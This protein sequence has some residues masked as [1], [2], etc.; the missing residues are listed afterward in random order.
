M[1][2]SRTLRHLSSPQPRQNGFSLIELLV[3]MAI[4]GIL[5][6]IAYPAYTQHKIKSSRAAAQSYMLE[7][8]VAQVSF[9][10]DRRRYAT[11]TTELSLAAPYEVS[12]KYTVRIDA[13]NTSRPQSFLITA[14]PLT[15]SIQ[16]PD[17]ELTLSSTGAKT[18]SGKW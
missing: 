13:V 1:S 15:N 2:H 5:S 4:I 6:A 18:P 9:L 7:L 8:G 14:V 3:T 12:S 11:S 16:S 17:G 10:M